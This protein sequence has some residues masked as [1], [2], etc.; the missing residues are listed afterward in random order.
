MLNLQGVVIN[1][2]AGTLSP[3]FYPNQAGFELQQTALR[4]IS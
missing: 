2:I 1:T 3:V 4:S